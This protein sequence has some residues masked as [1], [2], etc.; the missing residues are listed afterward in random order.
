MA[1]AGF[2]LL[3]QDS[4]GVVVA[5]SVLS[6]GSTWLSVSQLAELR[7]ERNGDCFEC[8]HSG[9][10]PRLVIYDHIP[11]R[12]PPRIVTLLTRHDLGAFRRANEIALVVAEGL[13][14]MSDF[15]QAANHLLNRRT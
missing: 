1:E 2:G 3:R 7:G 13:D 4:G 10:R 15:W 8:V 12:L 11:G 6:P 5:V 9:L 14:Y